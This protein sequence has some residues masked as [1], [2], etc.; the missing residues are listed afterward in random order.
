MGE[1]NEMPSGS[2]GLN[3]KEFASLLSESEEGVKE[4]VDFGKGTEHGIGNFF[5]SDLFSLPCDYMLEKI[6]YSVGQMLIAGERPNIPKIIFPQDSQWNIYPDTGKLQWSDTILT[7][8]LVVKPV[9]V[10][11]WVYGALCFETT[12]IFQDVVGMVNRNKGTRYIAAP[13]FPPG[14]KPCYPGLIR[15]NFASELMLAKNQWKKIL[16]VVQEISVSK[17]DEIESR[18]YLNSEEFSII[19]AMYEK[20]TAFRGKKEN[21]DSEGQVIFLEEDEGGEA[22]SQAV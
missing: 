22:D 19:G 8:V 18:G 12:K 2:Y 10:L 13:W 9:Q 7:T 15:M 16:D 21:D 1:K 3:E 20:F 14:G 6:M 5:G 11:G 17:N 4:T